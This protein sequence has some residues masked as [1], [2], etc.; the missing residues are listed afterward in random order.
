MARAPLG[1][2]VFFLQPVLFSL[3]FSL[4]GWWRGWVGPL[5]FFVLFVAKCWRGG[6]LCAQL[7]K[8]RENV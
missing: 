3:I 8:D 1:A 7:R 2:R 6:I 4:E 5:I